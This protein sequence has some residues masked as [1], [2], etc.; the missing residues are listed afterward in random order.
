MVLF[1]VNRWRFEFIQNIQHFNHI[2]LCRALIFIRAQH[3][4]MLHVADLWQKLHSLH[5]FRSNQHRFGNI[6]PSA[7]LYIGHMF[8]VN[9]I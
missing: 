6:C 1:T 8:R 2:W 7:V 4:M 3:K 9:R 5:C